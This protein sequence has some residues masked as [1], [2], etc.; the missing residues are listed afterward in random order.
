MSKTYPTIEHII[1]LVYEETGVE[2]RFITG[3]SRV[4]R[5]ARAR[6][7]VMFLAREYTDFSYPRIGKAL[8]RDHTTVMHGVRAIYDLSYT[9]EK[10]V[11]SLAKIK[12]HVRRG[13]RSQFAPRLEGLAL[14]EQPKVPSDQSRRPL[15]RHRHKY[16]YGKPKSD[17]PKKERKCLK[18]Q[19]M[20]WSWGAGNQTCPTCLEYRANLSALGLP[21]GYIGTVT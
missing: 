10:L 4:P 3:K 17:T 7:M 9:D 6:Q 1:G 16:H 2:P 20:F 12:A 13:V 15:M 5:I 21:A 19:S 14:P 18:C 8:S 11:E